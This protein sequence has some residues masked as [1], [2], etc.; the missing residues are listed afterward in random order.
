MTVATGEDMDHPHGSGPGSP[1]GAVPAEI[2]RP[3]LGALLRPPHRADARRNYEALLAA[4]ATVF[5]ADGPQASLDKIARTAGV[6]NATLYRHFPTRRDLLVGVC[7]EEVEALCAQGEQL[8]VD[9]D[10]G[11]ALL[12]WL[13]AFIEHVTS[14]KGLAEALMTGR[15]EDSAV[16]AACQ[17]AIGETAAA[18]LAAALR[19]GAVRDDLEVADLLALVNAIALTTESTGAQ[20]ADRLLRL[21]YQGI[22]PRGAQALS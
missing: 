5:A 1:I 14:R 16:I 18:L 9:Q 3:G 4:A 15:S 8:A 11:P 7:V 19:A 6:G 10:P 2:H 13:H 17:G 22:G 21:L 20:H 12:G